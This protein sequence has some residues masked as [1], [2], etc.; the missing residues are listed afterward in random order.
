MTRFEILLDAR[1]PDFPPGAFA[2][3]DLIEGSIQWEL[4]WPVEQMNIA[5]LFESKGKGTPQCEVCDT[6]EL[7]HLSNRG[8]RRFELATPEWPWSFSG[9]LLSLVW[10]VSL[11]ATGHKEEREHSL[12]VVISPT[13]SEMDLYAYELQGESPRNY[14][15]KNSSVINTKYRKR[16]L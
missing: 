15:K 9:R 11:T 8:E 1:S 6:M 2:P 10:M 14:W 5:L 12:P 13:R 7:E 3:G 4:S 16:S